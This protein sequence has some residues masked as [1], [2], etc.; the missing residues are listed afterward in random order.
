MSKESKHIFDLRLIK[1]KEHSIWNWEE[2]NQDI[3]DYEIKQILVDI[4]KYASSGQKRINVNY[5][6]ALYAQKKSVQHIIAHEDKNKIEY[7][8]IVNANG[9]TDVN[10]GHRKDN[11][12]ERSLTKQEKLLGPG[13]L[14]SK[15]STSSDSSGEVIELEI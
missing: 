10:L 6:R 5:L 3:T 9:D 14:R 8:M 11:G 1:K 4:G 7:D 15:R 13:Y 2:L 12:R